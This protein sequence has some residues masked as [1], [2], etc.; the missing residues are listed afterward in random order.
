MSDEIKKYERKCKNWLV[1]FGR[2]TLPR[3]EAPET[4][5]FWTAL[6]SLSSVLKRKVFVPKRLLGSWSASPNLYI[7][8]IAPPGRARKSTTAN[9][10]EDLLDNIPNLT[11]APELITKEK[12]LERLVKS[13]DASMCIVAPE[14]GEFIAKS[15]PSMYGFLTNMYDGKK[16]ISEDTFTRGANFADK[17][18]VNLL[19]AT[20]PEWVA[21]NMPESVIGGGFASRVI[22]IYEEK[23]RRR[24][25]WYDDI[26]QVEINQLHA[27][28]Q[29]DLLH[30]AENLSGEFIPTPEAKEWLDKWYTKNAD[31]GDSSSYKLSGYFERKPAHILKIAMLLHIAHSDSLVLEVR[32]LEDAV[33]QLKILEEKLPVVFQSVGGNPYTADI[34]RILEYITEKGRVSKEEVRRHF[35]HAATPSMLIELIDS[36]GAMGFIEIEVRG[37]ETWLIPCQSQTPLT[38]Q[39]PQQHHQENGQESQDHNHVLE[40]QFLLNEKL[41]NP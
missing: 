14:F 19:G 9:Y 41:Q 35:L 28:L 21:E 5:I 34:Y 26:N 25:I 33:R 1:D 8:F 31:E 22:F 36:L 38:S 32:D 17:P 4:F 11:R 16:N 27:N 6:F 15:G 18:C 13:N 10:V 39:I 12:L 40:M 23:V 7:L 30:I 20:T 3:S 24:K 2:W 37:T 29:A